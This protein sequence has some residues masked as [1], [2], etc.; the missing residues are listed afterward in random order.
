[1]GRRQTFPSTWLASAHTPVEL[2]ISRERSCLVH[3]CV[4]RGLILQADRL[5]S[6]GESRAGEHSKHSFHV[7]RKF[8][9]ID[10]LDAS[11]SDDHWKGFNK[12]TLNDPT[13]QAGRRSRIPGL[14]RG[15]LGLG[16]SFP[17]D[18]VVRLAIT[19]VGIQGASWCH[20]NARGAC[21]D[22]PP[23]ELVV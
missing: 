17:V 8:S 21:Q 6:P 13:T 9:S 12:H 19:I 10:T 14:N 20:Q 4:T 15:I 16:V 7:A 1:M 2:A 23:T 3:S 18:H 22:P 5:R 11:P